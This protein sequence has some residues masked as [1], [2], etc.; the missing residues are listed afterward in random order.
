MLIKYYSYLP[1]NNDGHGPVQ[2]DLTIIERCENLVVHGGIYSPDDF[3]PQSHDPLV[4]M[5]LDVHDYILQDSPKKKFITFYKE[6]QLTRLAVFGTAYVC[7]NDGETIEK[8]CPS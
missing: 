8:V 6:G 7:N 4:Y 2:S 5:F 3:G 1:N